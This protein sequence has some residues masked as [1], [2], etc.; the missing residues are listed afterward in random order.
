MEEEFEDTKGATTD[1]FH[2]SQ[3]LPGPFL[4]HDLS[5]GL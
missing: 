5:P 2:L 3:S 4:V 1:M